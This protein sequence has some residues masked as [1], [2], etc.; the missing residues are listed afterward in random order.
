[1]V[2]GRLRFVGA[3]IKLEPVQIGSDR[4]CDLEEARAR[5][6]CITNAYPTLIVYI[7]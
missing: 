6:Q 5:G 7:R 3:L 1:M 2:L 4:N